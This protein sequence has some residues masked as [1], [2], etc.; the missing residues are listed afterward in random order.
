M[1]WPDWSDWPDSDAVTDFGLAMPVQVHQAEPWPT[2]EL[3]TSCMASLG[4]ASAGSAGAASLGLL[5]GWPAT[6][7]P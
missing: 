5:F 3:A 7:S 1:R 2:A 6:E 4:L